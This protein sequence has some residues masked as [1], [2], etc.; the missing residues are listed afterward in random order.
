[1]G[2]FLSLKIFTYQLI[3]RISLKL[4]SNMKLG[5]YVDVT[6]FHAVGRLFPTFESPLFTSP[7]TLHVDK[8][9]QREVMHYTVCEN[10]F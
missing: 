9:V 2:F 5:M 3:E 4:S 6:C 8:L 7:K 10:M 1:M